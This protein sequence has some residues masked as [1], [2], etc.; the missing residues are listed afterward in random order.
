[1]SGAHGLGLRGGWDPPDQTVDDPEDPDEGPG[2][3]GQGETS[4][5]QGDQPVGQRQG[6]GAGHGAGEQP[7]DAGRSGG[8]PRVLAGRGRRQAETGAHD[9]GVGHQ[10][11]EEAEGHGGSEH[12]SPALGVPL[13]G[14]Q[15]RVDGGRIGPSGFDARPGALGPFPQMGHPLPDGLTSRS[16]SPGGVSAP[17]GGC[18]RHICPVVSGGH[19]AFFTQRRR[20]GSLP[21]GRSCFRP[22][23]ATKE[24]HD[25]NRVF[26]RCRAARRAPRTRHERP[27]SGLSHMR[28]AHRQPY[29]GAPPDRGESSRTF[30]RMARR[31]VTL[32]RHCPGPAR[33]GSTAQLSSTAW[34]LRIESPCRRRSDRELRASRSAVCEQPSPGSRAPKG[35]TP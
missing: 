29:G 4:E 6:A 13:D 12:A 18:L 19:A 32:A 30:D 33:E 1:M 31:S 2:R 3:Q 10:E 27:H 7:G 15:R 26:A 14:I 11:H 5:D 34:V 35:A 17:W 21:S 9:E 28:G 25:L 24:H 23:S 16:G 20:L 22:A 8:V